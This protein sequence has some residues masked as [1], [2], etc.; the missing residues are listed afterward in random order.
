M[1][2]YVRYLQ[3]SRALDHFLTSRHL[4]RL[5]TA[6]MTIGMMAAFGVS[7]VG[8][9]QVRYLS[10][11]DLVSRI[12]YIWTYLNLLLMLYCAHSHN[13][14]MMWRTRLNVPV[15]T[16][17]MGNVLVVHLI[18]A[19]MAFGLGTV[20]S[21]LQCISTYHLLK[22]TCS[23]PIFWVRVAS[24][25]I[26]TV[27]LVLSILLLDLHPR[28]CKNNLW[29]YAPN[30]AEYVFVWLVECQLLVEKEL[31]VGEFPLILM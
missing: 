4:Y 20:Y 18:G 28:L 22:L 16:L 9:F 8:N 24:S 14:P 5:N 13:L 21:W 19:G 25:F 3:V 12:S 11:L 10:S 7:V 15:F 26:A 31:R 30:S 6:S 1:T 27:F 29:R 2:I 17:K 23:R